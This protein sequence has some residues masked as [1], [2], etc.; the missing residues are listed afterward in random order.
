M[1]DTT[2]AD[3]VVRS[4]GMSDPKS[5]KF[6]NIRGSV[7]VSGKVGGNVSN[8]V[9]DSFNDATSQTDRIDLLALA[10]ELAQLRSAMREQSQQPGHDIATSEVARAEVAAR[11]GDKPA[12][13]QH[14]RDAGE[15]A[16]DIAKLVGVPVAIEALKAALGL[17]QA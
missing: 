15:W 13:F 9:A 1:S 4:E 11:G 7:V 6:E 3:P 14:L 12:L 8:Q 2:K 10:D 5:Q 16:L 17:K